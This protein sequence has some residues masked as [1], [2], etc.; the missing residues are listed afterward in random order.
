MVE[1]TCLEPEQLEAD[2]FSHL[3]ADISSMESC[4]VVLSH[5]S[6]SRQRLLAGGATILNQ[7][8]R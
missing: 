6:N 7:W 4:K 8:K 3:A 5:F 1:S 2:R